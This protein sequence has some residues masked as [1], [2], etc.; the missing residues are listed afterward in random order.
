MDPH[1]KEV[2]KTDKPIVDLETSHNSHTRGN[3]D[4]RLN[5]SPL[6]DASQKTQGVAIVLDELTERKKLE[7]QRR[8]F[9]RMVS[10]AV[11]E[12]LDPNGL[13]VAGAR[14]WGRV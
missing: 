6:K 9:E 1:L 12:Q 7:A 13:Q 8:L 14:R 4:W 11:I 2:R 10:P 5:L 3:V